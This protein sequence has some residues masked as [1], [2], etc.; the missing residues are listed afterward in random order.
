MRSHL[1][2]S[3]NFP[4]A[5]HSMP[6]FRFR[7]RWIAYALLLAI[8]F[9]SV[10]AAIQQ[11]QA[12]LVLG[13]A[14]EREQFAAEFAKQHPELPIWISSGSN[15][16]YSEWVF[17]EAGIERDR[18][19]LDYRAVDTLTNFTTFADEFQAQGI[20][21]VYVITS[22]DH[23]RR[24]WVIGEIVFTSRGIEFKSVE[25]PTGR[26]PESWSKVIRDAGRAVLWVATG[27]TG[28]ELADYFQQ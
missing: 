6:R 4:S 1:T 13:G 8:A 5:T 11:P 28:K 19:H 25:V 10:R 14:T 16:E 9:K 23:M 3:D 12:I 21:S 26:S 15:P 18:I 22:D 24:A 7:K 2:P 20:D 17:D 27:D